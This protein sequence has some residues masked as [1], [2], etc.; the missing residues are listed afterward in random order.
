M[1]DTSRSPT[2][3]TGRCFVNKAEGFDNPIKLPGSDAERERWQSANKAWWEA[4]PMRYDW[5]E[6]VP[7]EVGTREYYR[8][9]DRRFLASARQFLPWRSKPFDQLI[10]YSELSRLD[11]LEIGVGQ[12]THAQLIAAHAKSFTGIDLSGAAQKATSKRLETLGMPGRILQMDAEAL[13]FPDSTFDFIWSWGVIHHSADTRRLL[14]EMSRVLRPS[15][16]ATVMVYH[17]NWWNFFVVAGAFKGLIQGQLKELGSL[18]RIAQGATDGAIARYYRPAEWREITHG[19]FKIE[20]VR[21][22]GLK[23]DVIPL[24]P[25]R[26]K[27]FAERATPSILTRMLTNTMRMGSFLVV[28]MLRA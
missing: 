12:G 13:D 28:Q 24:P 25:G 1:S 16:R 23:N 27:A 19:L 26:I 22:C 2:N 20:R 3:F 7:F 4:M 11:V 6:S 8:E 21:I 15:G 18:H 5:R 10:P 14:T 17:R 9:I